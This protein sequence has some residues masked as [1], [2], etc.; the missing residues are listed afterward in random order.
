MED[1]APLI[2]L[3]GLGADERLFAPQREAFPN[4]IVPKWIT[5]TPNESI[6]SYAGRL[7]QHVDPRRPCYVG[8]MSFGG[9]LAMEMAKHLQTTAIFLIATLRG[10]EELP[11]KF[12]ML[13]PIRTFLSALPIAMLE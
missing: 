5:P 9:F 13:K 1:S 6:Q 8:G 12:R 10:P 11:P 4:L 2:L 3:S 7:A